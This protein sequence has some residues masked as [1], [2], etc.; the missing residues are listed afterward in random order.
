MTG[1]ANW[2]KWEMS[3]LKKVGRILVF[4]IALVAVLGLVLAVIGLFGGGEP[5]DGEEG[6]VNLGLDELDSPERMAL[7]VYL[8]THA[9]ALDRPAGADE[10]P[11]TFV[12]E[13]GESVADIAGRLESAGLIADAELFRRYLQYHDMDS[14]I[15]AGD[16][17]LRQ[18]M[19]IPQVAASLQEGLRAEQVIT[20]REGLRLEQVAALVG[21]QT[22]IPADE[23]LVVAMSGWRQL[24]LSHAF[25]AD[26]PP[27]ATLEG[28]LFPDTYRIYED[29]TAADLVTLM[30][31]TFDAR[32]PPDLRASAQTE[33]L[34]IY[35]LVTLASIIEREAV[36]TEERPIIAGVFHNRLDTGWQLE[37][38]PTVQYSLAEPGNWWPS[39]TLEDLDRDLPYS[40]YALPGLP[41]GP[42]C[43][44]GLNSIQ[45]AA[46]PAD[47]EYFFFLADC[48]ADDGSHLFAVTAEEHVANF[49]A[50]G[51]DSLP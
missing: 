16:F 37:S 36:L 32:V 3:L 11:V 43:S 47:V 42:I 15:E 34:D 31:D 19:T 26:L 4:V 48:S 33:G 8:E 51:A 49:Q 1:I 41:P 22:T 23:F 6:G 21:E 35:Q 9:D 40:T 28:F 25:L 30:L 10:T 14:S 5:A 38:C 12:I 18:T 13:S 17:V 27:D 50:C 44:P 2:I 46:N 24:A 45:A 39:L 29:A 20:I 7:R